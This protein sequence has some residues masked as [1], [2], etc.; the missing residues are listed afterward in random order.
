M[1]RTPEANPGL[2]NI[3]HI[4]GQI[5]EAWAAGLALA[6]PYYQRNQFKGQM[7]DKEVMR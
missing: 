3:H 5:G 1:Y 4:K 7:D 2:R 6:R